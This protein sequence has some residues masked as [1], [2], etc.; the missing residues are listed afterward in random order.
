MLKEGH[1]VEQAKIKIFGKPEMDLKVDHKL[2][3]KAMKKPLD[4]IEAEVARVQH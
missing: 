3:R 2:V 1:L 4:F